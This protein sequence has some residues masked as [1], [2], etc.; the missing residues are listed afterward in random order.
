MKQVYAFVL[1]LLFLSSLRL[2]AQIQNPY[3]EL[4]EFSPHQTLY[5]QGRYLSFPSSGVDMMQHSGTIDSHNTVDDY[6]WEHK[7]LYNSCSSTSAPLYSSAALLER[8]YKIEM[9]DGLFPDT[10]TPREA[11]ENAPWYDAVIS[12]SDWNYSSINPLALDSG[13][14]YYDNTNAVFKIRTGSYSRTDTVITD[15]A[16]F[17]SGYPRRMG[18]YQL[19]SVY[20]SIDSLAVNNFT[21][22]DQ[23]YFA[24]G[25]NS[26]LIN[27]NPADNRAQFFVP[28][29]LW[30]TNRP[31]SELYIDFGNGQAPTRVQPNTT[32]N[33]D[34]TTGGKY[35]VRLLEDPTCNPLDGICVVSTFE[36]MVT[37][38]APPSLQFAVD[39]S[40]IQNFCNLDYHDKTGHEKDPNAL[41]FGEAVVSVWLR[42]NNPDPQGRITR[43]VIVLD[44]FNSYDAIDPIKDATQSSGGVIKYGKINAISIAS[45]R[46]PSDDG[47]KESAS[48]GRFPDFLD[49]VTTNDYD[50]V[51]IDWRTNR[52]YIRANANCFKE[53]LQQVNHQMDL[54]GSSEEMI[55]VGASMGG[56]IGRV[57]L[58]EMELEECC[59][60]TRLYVSFDSPHHGAHIPLSLQQ[61]IHSFYTYYSV[62]G[63]PVGDQE[64]AKNQYEWVLASPAAREMLIQHREGNTPHE[65][66]YSYLNQIGYPEIPERIAITNGSYTGMPQGSRVRNPM[67]NEIVSGRL[68][69]LYEGAPYLELNANLVATV[70]VPSDWVFL[71]RI[72]KQA[73]HKSNEWVFMRAKAYTTIHD[74][75]GAL[76][77]TILERGA[78]GTVNIGGYINH[79]SLMFS[80]SGWFYSNVIWHIAAMFSSSAC[81]PCPAILGASMAV[82]SAVISQT[83][84]AVLQNSLDANHSLNSQTSGDITVGAI[85]GLDHVPGSYISTPLDIGTDT[86]VFDVYNKNHT[87]MATTS[88]IGLDTNNCNIDISSITNPAVLNRIPF[89]AIYFNR[90]KLENEQAFISH[91]QEHVEMTY[92]ALGW[93]MNQFRKSDRIPD[94]Y[95]NAQGVW[96]LDR[97]YNFGQSEFSTQGLTNEE[98]SLQYIPNVIVLRGG[99][100]KVNL[101]DVLGFGY[102]IDR[103]RQTAYEIT[104]TS[105][106]CTNGPSH[107][108]ITAGGAM[109]VGDSTFAAQTATVYFPASSTL[110]VSGTLVVNN[111]SQLKLEEG[112]TL[113][114]HPGARIVLN[115]PDARFTIAGNVHLTANAVLTTEGTGVL[116]F[117]IPGL[118]YG[119]TNR[120]IQLD[121]SNQF[122]V[123][124]TDSAHF[125]LLVSETLFLTTAWDSVFLGTCKV[126]IAHKE[127][128]DLRS[129][130]HVNDITVDVYDPLQEGGRLHEGIRIYGNNPGV[131]ENSRFYHGKFGLFING[132]V[133]NHKK[134]TI[135]HCR[136]AD[137]LEGASTRGGSMYFK[138]SVFHHNGIGL[139][140]KD[141]EGTCTIHHCQF[142]GNDIGSL[143]NSMSTQH[144]DVE[145]CTYSSNAVGMHVADIYADVQCS[146]W[147]L[148]SIG[149]QSD[150]SKI[151]LSGLSTSEFVYN[152]TAISLYNS[153]ELYLRNGFNTFSG[154]T[155][156]V[157]GSFYFGGGIGNLTGPSS[158]IYYLDMKNNYPSGPIY[159]DVL[160]A[161]H[162]YSSVLMQNTAYSTLF[163]VCTVPKGPLVGPGKRQLV[164]TRQSSLTSLASHAG[165]CVQRVYTTPF[166][167]VPFGTGVQNL[168]TADSIDEVDI[169]HTL[170]EGVSQLS[171]VGSRDTSLYFTVLQ[172]CGNV[173]YGY[174]DSTATQTLADVRSAMSYMSQHFTSNYR[175]AAYHW[176]AMDARHDENYAVAIPMNTQAVALAQADQ[177]ERM[178]YWTCVMEAENLLKTG[179]IDNDEYLAYTD[180]CSTAFNQYKQKV[181]PRVQGST[182]TPAKV[183]ATIHPNPAADCGVIQLNECAVSRINMTDVHGQ[184]VGS[185][186]V[187]AEATEHYI[188]PDGV[189][190]GVYFVSLY[191]PQRQVVQTLTWI[192]QK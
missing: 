159:T 77:Q 124:G 37:R 5:E 56:Q 128:L 150:F 131:V 76:R 72:F 169:A 140:Y 146:E 164:S 90:T 123:N 66:Y 175:A 51:F 110:E 132:L 15:S 62:F 143:S 21:F 116:E 20:F 101:N 18:S 149:I 145:F 30:F 2:S 163:Q 16:N 126:N 80:Y 157:A 186:T 154:N 14:V 191:N 44:G 81:I 9:W 148:N 78:T 55:V 57:G 160:L 109:V 33:V 1:G 7:E 27:V 141:Q 59:H 6:L 130:Y 182:P 67:N 73:I 50:F 11:I 39:G 183:A 162:N 13:Y 58:R 49:S 106:G 60:N 96:E 38:V 155:R 32:I 189:P 75:S 68:D 4:V 25:L 139:R 63:I 42:K 43:P 70:G 151:N 176:L 53:I 142:F 28:S 97:Y 64:K 114:L 165:Y 102:S 29:S 167:G 147:V 111:G 87:F 41:W 133:G 83:G 158:G 105:K 52:H 118:K 134:F 174:S 84:T 12:V 127:Y 168:L 17:Y 71:S 188:C 192:L 166:A 187:D 156:L 138:N 3:R 172:A 137:N 184:T 61:L 82:S 45:G 65:E 178:Q 35:H 69:T 8:Q 31:T 92:T 94:V 173:M 99:V 177:I 36:L 86:S 24:L 144:L 48:L 10:L 74:P 120:V 171:L 122:L 88:T 136:F 103:A 180:S 100:L 23:R 26:Q 22:Q 19:D 47:V 181:Q 40:T 89:S 161:A 119:T 129:A 34:F 152:D 104:A 113:V 115:G 91:N 93:L 185:W 79:L 46:F 179:A 54:A 170:V 117:A 190:S 135:S 121:G 125:K 85:Q 112:S 107:V 108:N 153:E 98:I 95:L